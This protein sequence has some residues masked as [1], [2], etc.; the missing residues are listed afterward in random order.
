MYDDDEIM[1]PQ[2]MP[3]FD[4]TYLATPN[5]QQDEDVSSSLVPKFSDISCIYLH[6]RIT[7][8]ELL[9]LCLPLTLLPASRGSATPN[10]VNTTMTSNP[11]STTETQSQRPTRPQCSAVLPCW[12]Q[13]MG[14]QDEAE[15]IHLMS[16]QWEGDL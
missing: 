13:W 7:S 16:P 10:Y 15:D 3:W 11:S 6:S 5:T 4:P 12:Q 14:M 9:T 1:G 8:L 2:I